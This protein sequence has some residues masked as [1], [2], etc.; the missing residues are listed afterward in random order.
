MVDFQLIN[1]TD[2]TFQVS[3]AGSQVSITLNQLLDFETRSFYLLTI[4]AHDRGTPTR[5]SSATLEIHVIDVADSIPQFNSTSYSVEIAEDTSPPAYLLTVQATSQDSAPLAMLQYVEVSGDSNNHFSIDSNTGVITLTKTLDFETTHVYVIVVQAQSVANP[6]RLRSQ[7]NVQVTV[8]NVN[9]HTPVFTRPMYSIAI[10]ETVSPGHLVMR[11]DAPDLD[12]GTFGDVTYQFH[13]STE[14]AVNVTFM[15]DPASGQITTARRLD[16]EQREQYTFIVK[17]TDGGNP[18]RSSTSRV[19]ITVTDVNDEPPIFTQE[20]YSAAISEDLDV[21]RSVIQVSAEDSDSTASTVTYYIRSGNINNVFVI[22]S[23]DGLIT[24]RARLNREQQASY[25]LIVVATD[26]S[27]ENTTH[28]LI[29]VLDLNDESPTFDRTLYDLPPVAED[30]RVGSEIGR[31]QAMDLDDGLN[32]Q[33][34]Y[35][36]T[37]I[38]QKFHLNNRTG[39]ITLSSSLD[40]EETERYAFDVTATDGGQP[41]L[42][43]TARVQI[44]VLDV[45][46]NFP[47]F[48]QHSNARSISENESPGMT[49]TTV[50]AT[51]ADSGS[52]SDI[53][54]EIIGDT[55]ARRAFGIRQ[56]GVIYTRESL[57][58]EV[59]AEYNLIIQASDSGV[60][61][62]T[63]TT[64]LT[65]NII[66]V[67]DYRPIFTMVVY[68]VDIT[69]TFSRGLPVVTVNATTRDLVPPQSI[70]YHI[71]SG[72]NST[73][74]RMDQTTGMIFAETTIDPVL[75]E[76][77]YR[78]GVMAQH[79]HLSASVFVIM[80][81]RPD[82]GIP[83]LR[84]L[85]VYFSGYPTLVGSINH[86]GVVEIRQ[87]K[88]EQEYS[89]S[90]IY[91]DPRLHRYF[92]INPKTGY[93]S[94]VHGVVSGHYRLNVSASTSTGIG[95]AVVDVF[96]TM[97]TN[98]TLENAVV[99]TFGA[100]REASF[101]SIQLD[102]FIQFLMATVPCYRS[103]VE[104]VGIQH[105][106]PESDE[107]VSVSFS[108]LQP[109]L[110]SYVP[111]KRIVDILRA[112]RHNVQPSTLSSFIS[113]VCSQEPCSNLQRCHPV[114]EVRRHSPGTPFKTVSGTKE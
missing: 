7:T 47:I 29:T 26:E 79:M 44:S 15:L 36:S 95:S 19:S 16:R 45:N 24:T 25:D 102:Q 103:Q 97:L 52:N 111:R 99:A 110:M 57:D 94:V 10:L 87:P 31:V 80:R 9:D 60:V 65:I 2:N 30:L 46:D 4:S 109:D 82:D 11:V 50:T 35:S 54:Y 33:V 73:L 68:E 40:Y 90:L 84:P 106:G 59:I 12:E 18:P 1:N 38:D 96:V 113:D 114:V 56:N 112:N 83:R 72:A 93:L 23:V 6:S 69:S 17:A 53:R 32:G 104:I 78:I 41:T 43:G 108:I 75:H 100:A 101:A 21:G 105:V 64:S 42:S 48:E 55:H 81:V 91:S 14:Q 34:T 63:A 62:K 37:N 89:F 77:T 61:R 27:N 8:T 74:F 13:E 67:I 85:T 49:V 51:D 88:M 22:D 66:D 70:I 3:E 76:G 107:I 98:Q 20:Q 86:L 5:S 71:T 92:F 28:V 39:A 58:R